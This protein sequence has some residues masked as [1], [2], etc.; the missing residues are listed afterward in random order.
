[1]ETA[2]PIITAVWTSIKRRILKG[3]LSEPEAYRCYK[4]TKKSLSIYSHAYD[5]IDTGT[6][7]MQIKHL[8]I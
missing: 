7:K 3:R 5:N 6:L 8:H 1:M 4:H 2:M